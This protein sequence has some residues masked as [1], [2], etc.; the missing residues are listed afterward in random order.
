MVTSIYIAGVLLCA[1]TLG[2]LAANARRGS[3]AARERGPT[4]RALVILS[5]ALLNCGLWAVLSAAL[6]LRHYHPEPESSAV[7]GSRVLCLTALGVGLFGIVLGLLSTVI[8]V[9]QK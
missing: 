1:S 2:F 7:Y 6:G 3:S 9:R 4:R 5:V 8:T